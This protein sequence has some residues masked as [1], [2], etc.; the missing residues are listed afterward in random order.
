MF[1]G[2]FQQAIDSKN[3][4]VIPVKFRQFIEDEQDRKGFVITSYGVERDKYLMLYTPNTWREVIGR[5]KDVSSKSENAT[6]M[7]R[8]ISANAEYS[9][10]DKQGRLVIPQKLLE[11]ASLKRDVMIVG[12]VNRIEVWNLED[13]NRKSDSVKKEYIDELADIQKEL[14][15]F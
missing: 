5:A 4:I 9:S 7:L 11:I 8:F 12:I 1:S 15:K 13:W 3:R 10:I 14:F 2:S 6:E